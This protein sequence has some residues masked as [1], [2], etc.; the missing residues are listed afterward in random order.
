MNDSIKSK[1]TSNESE[2]LKCLRE[3][4]ELLTLLLIRTE[5]KP[6]EQVNMKRELE[7][8]VSAKAGINDL[9]VDAESRY[10]A[11]EAALASNDEW[12]PPLDQLSV[13]TAK[14]YWSEGSIQMDRFK[15]N[16]LTFKDLCEGLGNSENNS[17]PT[18]LMRHRVDVPLRNAVGDE[19]VAHVLKGLCAVDTKLLAD[20]LGRV[21]G[22][23][24]SRFPLSSSL[25]ASICLIF[26]IKRGMDYDLFYRYYS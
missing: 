12:L 21:K 4:K 2:T 11:L 7:G 10:V 25:F 22:A 3:I 5:G 17:N 18:R 23:S 9:M 19:L 13:D 8:V 20:Y 26:E 24:L 6:F 1:V 16:E 14:K 15:A